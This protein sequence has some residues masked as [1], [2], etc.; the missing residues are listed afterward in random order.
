MFHKSNLMFLCK[1]FLL[2]LTYNV[3]KV[4]QLNMKFKGFVKALTFVYF[5]IFNK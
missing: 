2:E 4:L 1:M 3:W 5:E